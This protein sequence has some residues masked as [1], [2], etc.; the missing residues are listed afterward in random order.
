[1][2]AS[3]WIMTQHESRMRK[4]DP[5]ATLVWG[6]CLRHINF[7]FTVDKVLHKDM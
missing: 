1:M 5:E 2:L 3:E 6:H 4:L 7:S